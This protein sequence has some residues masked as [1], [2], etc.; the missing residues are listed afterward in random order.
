[1]T[2]STVDPSSPTC[3][4]C[5]HFQDDPAEI[6]RR[7]PGIRILGSAWGSTRGDAGLCGALDRFQ[8]PVSGNECPLFEARTD[9]RRCR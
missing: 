8:D 5:V 7:L 9:D 1:M 3:R 2:A 6:E 4:E